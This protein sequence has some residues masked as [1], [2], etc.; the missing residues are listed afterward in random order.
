MGFLGSIEDRITKGFKNTGVC[1][2][3]TT[4]DDAATCGRLCIKVL[5]SKFQ[6]SLSERKDFVLLNDKD[7]KLST[8]SKRPSRAALYISLETS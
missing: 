1:A 5:G 7:A 3:S 4:T 8:T 6:V 2:R